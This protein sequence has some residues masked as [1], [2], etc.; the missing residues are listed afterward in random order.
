MKRPHICLLA[1]HSPG[2]GPMIAGTAHYLR[3]VE[4]T[5]GRVLEAPATGEVR[6][7]PPEK[8]SECSFKARHLDFMERT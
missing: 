7:G 3:P 4:E 8:T 5:P 6:G 1:A 2:Q